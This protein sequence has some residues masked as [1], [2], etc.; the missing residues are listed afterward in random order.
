MADVYANTK[1]LTNFVLSIIDDFMPRKTSTSARTGAS[2]IL[3]HLGALITVSMWGYSFVSSKVLLEHGMGPTEIYVCRFIL[4]YILILF[5]SH[6]RLFSNSLRDEVLFML[7]GLC[8]GSIYFIAENTAL[9]YTLTTNVSLLTSMSPLITAM[10]VGLIYR[11]EKIGAGMWI[12]SVFAVIGVGCVV[13]NSSTDLQIRPLGDFLSLAAA[14]SWAVYSLILRKLN[15]GYDVWFISRK[16]FFYGLVTAVPF[17][18]FET[19][20]VN[21]LDIITEPAVWGNLLFLGVGAS[22]VAYV[23]WAETVK[24]VGAVKANVYMYLQPVVTLVVSVF[25]LGERVTFVGYLGIVLILGGLWLGDYL[26]RKKI[27]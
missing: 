17:L 14:F 3:G 23:L 20:V 21:P 24:R 4:A 7:C 8:A 11:T 2:S 1:N 9:E 13:F 6:S 19:N 22:T 16:T 5:M 18:L 12:G 26:T 15:A 27:R 25:V 10:L